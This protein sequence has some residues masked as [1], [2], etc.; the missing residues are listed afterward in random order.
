M[1]R[2]K[3]TGSGES[4]DYTGSLSS[5]LPP[6]ASLYVSLGLPEVF[7]KVSDNSFD[8]DDNVWLYVPHS[9]IQTVREQ[10]V[11][12][13]ESEP[14]VLIPGTPHTVEGMHLYPVL[15]DR[16]VVAFVTDTEGATLQADTDF[17]PVIA[18][19]LQQMSIPA[20]RE[21]SQAA[22]R[23]ITTLFQRDNS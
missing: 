23:F 6:S 10:S 22:S 4:S 18:G 7:K 15:K 11:S 12:S 5:A 21:P 8:S 14:D 16:Q 2:V 1:T 17:T 19:Y 20:K 3:A 13:S 9:F